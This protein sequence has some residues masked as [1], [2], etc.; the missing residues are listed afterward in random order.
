MVPP[1]F[2]ASACAAAVPQ[3]K[4]AA[5]AVAAIATAREARLA[6]PPSVFTLRTIVCSFGDHD[7]PARYA[8]RSSI[9]CSQRLPRMRGSSR[10][11]NASPYTLI[12]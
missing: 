8:G 4:A 3:A 11:R 12:A 7:V 6:I 2:G 5:I 10:S 9:C 1:Y